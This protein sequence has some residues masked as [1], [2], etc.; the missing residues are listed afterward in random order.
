MKNAA[1][2]LLG[3][4]C[5]NMIAEHYNVPVWDTQK[6]WRS[7]SS[8]SY[9]RGANSTIRAKC[10]RVLEELVKDVKSMQPV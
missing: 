8:H 4:W 6:C 5:D 7:S 3:V 9:F 1:N 2:P 10:Q